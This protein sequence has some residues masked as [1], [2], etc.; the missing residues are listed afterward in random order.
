MNPLTLRRQ[1]FIYAAVILACIACLTYGRRSAECGETEVLKAVVGILPQKYILE[2]LGGGHVEVSVLIGPGQTHGIY[3]PSPQTISALAK[4]RVFFGAGLPL[5]KILV[6]QAKDAFSGLLFVDTGLNV[7]RKHFDDHAHIADATCSLTEGDPHYW[8]DPASVKIQAESMFE[9]ITKLR[10]ELS[11]IF[12]EN[13]AKLISDLDS[14]RIEAAE[15]LEPH[16][17]KTM[18]VFH[19]AYGYFAD[20]FGLKQVAIEREGKGPSP[21]QLA[22]LIRYAKKENIRTIF[23]QPQYPSKAVNSIAESLKCKVV[24]LDPLDPDYLNNF[25]RI[26]TEVERA[27]SGE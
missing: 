5:E 10:P 23:V 26:V 21:R 27:F 16:R 11:G 24:V 4:A 19:P 7:P 15:K 9:T 13:Y 18:F 17:G 25:R 20:A 12:A 3:D 1:L 2:R 6:E 8:L 14:L 22:E